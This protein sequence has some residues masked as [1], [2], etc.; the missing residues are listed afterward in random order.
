MPSQPIR[1][2]GGITKSENLFLIHGVAPQITPV[3][4]AL[5]QDLYSSLSRT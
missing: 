1:D 5:R 2:G 3:I 4:S